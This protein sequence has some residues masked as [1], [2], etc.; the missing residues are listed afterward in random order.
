VSQIADSM[1]YEEVKWILH[2]R[3]H[4][5]KY[6]SYELVQLYTREIIKERARTRQVKSP[7]L[8]HKISKISKS[9]EIGSIVKNEWPVISTIPYFLCYNTK[10]LSNRRDSSLWHLHSSHLSQRAMQ[11]VLR[12][13]RSVQTVQRS[14]HRS[15][16]SVLT[17]QRSTGVVV[18]FRVCSLVRSKDRGLI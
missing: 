1:L 8:I 11:T 2:R 18:R 3:P 4:V 9:K 15:N 10:P 5:K 14:V 13:N 7:D 6:N 16:R 12:S 17:V